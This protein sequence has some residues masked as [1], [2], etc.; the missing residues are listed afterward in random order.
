MADEISSRQ[1]YLLALEHEEADRVPIFI[2]GLPCAFYTDEVRWYNQFERAL[3]M[4][5]LGCDPMI[6]IWLPTPVPS[7]EVD[8]RTWREKK[9]GKIYLGKEFDTPKG[10]LRQVVEETPDWVSSD[11]GYWVQRTLENGSKMTYGMDVF[12]DYSIPRRIEPWVKGKEDLPKLKYVLQ[13]P[14]KWELDEWRHDTQ[15]AM[16]FA[17]EHELLTCVRRTVISDASEWFCGLEWFMLQLYDDPEFVEEFLEIFEEISGWQTQLGLEQKPD[18]F[19]RRGWYDTPEFWGG[20]HYTKYI[21]PSVKAQAKE[22]HEAGSYFAYLM[23]EGWGAYLDEFPQLGVDIFWGLDPNR[24]RTSLKRIKD[25]IGRSSTLLGGVSSEADII[26]SPPDKI[27]ETVR[28][29]IEVLAP[30]GGFILAP[31]VG[32]ERMEEK[33]MKWEKVAA[34]IDEAH[35]CG[36]Y[37]R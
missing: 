9:D 14:V 26:L 6:N 15:R 20:K 31:S 25:T 21:A 32:L 13:K 17:L 23:P 4:K 8:I 36:R 35:D 7:P 28:S 10:V 19:Q 12:D 29:S 2:D 18:V 1:R 22:V 30:G 16:E 37:Q 24:N 33:N 34:L 11:H 27:R 5:Q 3:V